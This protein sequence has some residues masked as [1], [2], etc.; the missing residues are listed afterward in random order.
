MARI[1]ITGSSDGIGQAVAK[2]LIQRGHQV[3]LHARNAPRAQQT[4]AAVPQAAGVLVADLSTIAGAQELT[5]QASAA[6]LWDA[7]VHNAGVGPSERRTADGGRAGGDV[8]GQ[9]AGPVRADERDGAAARAPAVPVERRAPQRRCEPRGRRVDAA[10]RRRRPRV[11]GICGLEA[12]RRAAGQR[13]GAPVAGHAGVRAG[14]GLGADEDGRRG[15]AGDDGGAGARDRG[16]RGRR[17]HAGGGRAERGVLHAVG[18]E[19]AAPCSVGH[20][21]ARRTAPDLRGVVRRG[22]SRVTRG[23]LCSSTPYL[24]QICIYMMLVA[25]TVSSADMTQHLSCK[26]TWNGLNLAISAQHS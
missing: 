18:D 19:A 12:A 4:R 22:V 16:V 10:R 3:T 17:G 8:R 13:R 24:T 20:A 23:A 26:E 21:E 2:L 1:F 14:P 25:N 11:P 7:V 5:R 6:G 9:H 15:R